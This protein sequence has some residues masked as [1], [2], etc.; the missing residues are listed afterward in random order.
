[1]QLRPNARGI[2]RDSGQIKKKGSTKAGTVCYGF[3]KL[4]IK[5]KSSYK[6]AKAICMSELLALKVP[7][8]QIRTA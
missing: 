5:M 2:Q 6:L 7:S 1:M 3:L 8:G 4:S